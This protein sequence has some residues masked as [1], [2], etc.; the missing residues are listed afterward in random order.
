VMGSVMQ[1]AVV[2]LDDGTPTGPVLSASF[3]THGIPGLDGKSLSK[4]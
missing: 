2:Q 4:R 1:S 3:F